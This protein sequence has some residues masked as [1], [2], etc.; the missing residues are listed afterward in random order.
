MRLNALGRASMN[1]PLR[2]FLQRRFMAPWLERLG[3][4]VPDGRGS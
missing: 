1:N 4:H 2:A 3:G